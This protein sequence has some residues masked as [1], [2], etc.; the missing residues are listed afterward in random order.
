MM[1]INKYIIHIIWAIPLEM[2]V[3]EYVA[4]GRHIQNAIAQI[5]EIPETSAFAQFRFYVTAC[6]WNNSNH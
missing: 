2:I 4:C 1:S 3:N 6:G 5:T